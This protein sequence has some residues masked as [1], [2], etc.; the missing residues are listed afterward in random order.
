[1]RLAKNFNSSL[2]NL[3]PLPCAQ[4]AYKTYDFIA[5]LFPNRSLLK[6]V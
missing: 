2:T 5:S 6:V 1:M 3:I 4:L